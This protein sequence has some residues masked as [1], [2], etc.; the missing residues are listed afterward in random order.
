M[1][2]ADRHEALLGLSAACHLP[3]D[4]NL[5]RLGNVFV[6]DGQEGFAFD[7]QT[8]TDGH[9]AGRSGRKASACFVGAERPRGCGQFHGVVV[10]PVP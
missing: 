8:C 4:P 6:A 5:G 10:R 9:A 1:I 7:W 3:G 2:V